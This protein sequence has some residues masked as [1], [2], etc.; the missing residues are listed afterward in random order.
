M[1]I[2]AKVVLSVELAGALLLWLLWRGEQPQAMLQA[3]FHA[4]SAFCNAGFSPFADSLARF[5]GDPATLAVLMALIVAGGIGAPVIADLA[6][7]TGGRLLPWAPDRRLRLA[8]RLVLGISFG[9]IAGGTFAY[10]LDARLTGRE[11]S[12][13]R[14]LFQSATTRTAGFQVDSQ[15]SFGLVGFWTTLL[16]MAIGASA[17]STGGGIKTNVLARLFGRVDGPTPGRSHFTGR[18]FRIALLLVG[19]YLATGAATGLLLAAL[20]GGP[21]GDAV[22]EAFSALGTVGL[23][24]DLTPELGA[25]GKC[26]LIALMFAGRVLYPTWALALVRRS[27]PG[28][29]PVDWV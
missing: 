27:P 5:A 11:G 4:I 29:D 15:L 19:G 12:L 1:G 20:E 26:L 16:L 17:Q 13:L 21:R 23:S 10:W 7:W 9:L 22:F 3:G 8:S 25:G 6:G 14:A 2:V 24:R 28:E 18:P